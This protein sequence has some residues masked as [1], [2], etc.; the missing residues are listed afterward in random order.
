MKDIGRYILSVVGFDGLCGNRYRD[1][2]VSASLAEWAFSRNR[3][4]LS[5]GGIR[6]SFSEDGTCSSTLPRTSLA[7]KAVTLGDARDGTL[8]DPRADHCVTACELGTCVGSAGRT[9]FG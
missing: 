8:S 4:N 1:L 3:P 2:S 7:R 5:N 9:S 6:V